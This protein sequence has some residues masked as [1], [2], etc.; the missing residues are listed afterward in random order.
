V[1][2]PYHFGG[3]YKETKLC[4]CVTRPDGELII[5]LPN[6][7]QQKKFVDDITKLHYTLQ[8]DQYIPYEVR[9]HTLPE[10]ANENDMIEAVRAKS[11][12]EP[13]SVELIP[14]RESNVRHRGLFFAGI[15][16]NSALYRKLADIKGLNIWW[17]WCQ[18]D[19]A[20][21]VIKCTRCGVLGHIS[22]NCNMERNLDVI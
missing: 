3:S 2:R 16:C 14:Y 9:F 1:V 12:M 13:M 11:G 18:V 4:Q 5:S 22:K 20:P 6:K 8:K 19:A 7:E 17:Q 21:C 15:S 10:G